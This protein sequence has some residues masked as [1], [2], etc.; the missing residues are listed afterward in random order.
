[1]AGIGLFDVKGFT[2]PDAELG[3]A[4]PL[5][6]KICIQLNQS[7]YRGREFAIIAR[8]NSGDN[9]YIQSATLNG[10]TLHRPFVPWPSIK[11]GGTLYLQMG[12]KEVDIY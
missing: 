12:K 9:K 8:D 5:F 6:N 2:E 10:K 1:M 4:S 7:Y 3:L 11:E